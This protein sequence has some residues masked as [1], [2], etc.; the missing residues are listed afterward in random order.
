MG[1]SHMSQPPQPIAMTPESFE[2]LAKDLGVTWPRWFHELVLAL[3]PHIQHHYWLPGGFLFSR[4]NSVVEM[5]E[6]Y[7][8]G[9]LETC[10]NPST[11]QYQILSWPQAYIVIGS[12]GLGDVVIDTQ[13][14]RSIIYV[15]DEGEL[16][17]LIDVGKCSN[18]AAEFAEGMVIQ[19]QR[20]ARKT[21]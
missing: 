7:R 8:A 14:Q 12:C 9:R 18:S 5:T 2:T 11:P 10:V 3:L 17:V 19:S 16:R 13:D 4:T 21:M 6:A 15:L 20:D 1:S